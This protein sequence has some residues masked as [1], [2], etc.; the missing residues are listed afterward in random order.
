MNRRGVLYD[1]GRV[2]GFNWRPVFDRAETRSD[3]TMIR[4]EL[5]CNAV[6]LCGRDLDR[7][8]AAAED[9]L[10]L[11]LEVWFS[12]ELWDR[13]PAPTLTYLAGAARAAE[14]LRRCAK[15]PDRVVLS[16]ATE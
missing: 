11:G 6:K 12:P 15:T 9:A 5:H 7:L 16:V 3:L 8:T 1:T 10:A 2:L 13:G 14:A 4:D